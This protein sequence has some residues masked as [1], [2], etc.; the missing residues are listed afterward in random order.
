MPTEWIEITNYNFYKYGRYA[1]AMEATDVFLPQE[2]DFRVTFNM[3]RVHGQTGVG[4][5]LGYVVD[6]DSRTGFTLALGRSGG[7]TVG[8]ASFG[9]EFGGDSRRT[10]THRHDLTCTYVDGELSAETGDSQDC[11]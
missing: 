6:D 10:N 4:V 8:K 11:R 3:S 5:G 1:A 9:F 7:E 2:Q